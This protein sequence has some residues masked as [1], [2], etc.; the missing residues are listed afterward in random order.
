[1]TALCPTCGNP[2][3]PSKLLVDLNNNT[4]TR[5]GVTVHLSPTE[6]EIMSVLDNFYPRRVSP[7]HLIAAVYG[8]GD[9]PSNAV[10][11]L[12]VVISKMRAKLG[13]IGVA[14][15]PGFRGYCLEMLEAPVTHMSRGPGRPWTDADTV[16]LRKLWGQPLSVIGERMKRS[17]NTIRQKAEMLKLAPVRRVA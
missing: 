8:A 14:L 13:L 16:M 3:E 6:A 2:V 12:S 7:P 10:A 11:V 15:P 17:I 5:L 4:A 9:E 1:M